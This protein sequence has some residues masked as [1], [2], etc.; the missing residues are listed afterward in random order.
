MA[1]PQIQRDFGLSDAEMSYAASF[2]GL[3]AILACATSCLSDRFGRARVLM[4]TLVPYTLATAFTALSKGV[5]SFALCQ[6]AAQAFITAEGIISHVMVLEEMPA[7]CRGW[8][9]GVLN[10]GSACGAGLALLLFGLSGGAWRLMY[11][12]SILPLCGVGILRRNLQ[13]TRRWASLQEPKGVQLPVSAA[14]EA[15]SE[16]ENEDTPLGILPSKHRPGQ[17][18]QQHVAMV[19]AAF[20]GSFFPS[21]ANFH[22]SK[23]IQTVHGFGAS[24]FAKL[25]LVGGMLSLSA[26]AIAGVVG[27]KYGRKRFGV[28]GIVLK[29]LVD[30]A[31]YSTAAGDSVAWVVALFCLRT[32][33]SMAL[34]TTFQA[35]SGEVFPTASRS[36][37]QGLLV[38]AAGLGGPLGL[39]LSTQWAKSMGGPAAAR[40][41]AWGQLGVAA[42]IGCFLP[43]T[44]GRE[45]EDING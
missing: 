18:K 31:F 30:V 8:A 41:L 12:L 21:A 45:L 17:V 33:L 6:L 25:S 19:V 7:D 24:G 20:L 43:E 36:S 16:A 39:L 22:T 32:A 26:F 14:N 29:T 42:I 13:E 2:V 4:W 11:A 3:S 28:L 1:V 23:H 34:D 40:L 44:K 37:A 38:L 35:L 27:D 15:A 10:I 9:V 5:Q